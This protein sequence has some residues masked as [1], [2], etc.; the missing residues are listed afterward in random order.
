MMQCAEATLVAVALFLVLRI[1][2]PPFLFWVRMPRATIRAA[3]SLGSGTCP[4]NEPA[5]PALASFAPMALVMTYKTHNGFTRKRA[6]LWR[7]LNPRIT[8]RVFDDTECLA[9]VRVSYGPEMADMLAGIPSGPIKADLF[10]ALYLYANG[11]IYVDIDSVPL[12]DVEHMFSG[13][14]FDTQ[15]LYVPLSRFTPF[16]NPMLIAASKGHPTLAAVIRMY[17]RL[18]TH[19]FVY[20]TYSIVNIMTSLQ[21]VGCPVDVHLHEVC[22]WFSIQ[23]CYLATANGTAVLANRGTDYNSRKHEFRS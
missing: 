22:P 4:M 19:P 1:C 6:Q 15:H 18:H 17:G 5:L 23:D 2:V 3:T 21:T 10:R 20:W 9:F 16:L 12:Q 7:D 13:V 14:P 8:V 11:G